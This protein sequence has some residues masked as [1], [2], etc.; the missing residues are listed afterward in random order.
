MNA[1]A[2]SLFCSPDDVI[3]AAERLG[4]L[5]FFKGTLPGLSI[6]EHTPDSL[7][8]S[9][10]QDG[11]WEWKGL[12]VRSAKVAYAKILGKKAVYVSPTWLPHIVNLRRA[13]RTLSYDEQRVLNAIV[14]NENM[15]STEIRDQ[16]GFPLPWRKG[17]RSPT[18]RASQWQRCPTR[19]A[20]FGPVKSPNGRANRGRRFRVQ[21]R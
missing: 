4:F 15:L 9:S 6:E 19:L 13:T 3:A 18:L 16:C 10:E 8:F 2:D 7:W 1:L 21:Y 5:P 11:P 14:A 17:C 20:R 12:I